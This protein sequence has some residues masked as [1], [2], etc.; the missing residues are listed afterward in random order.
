MGVGGG[1]GGVAGAGGD[2]GKRSASRSASFYIGG[3]R[4]LG[5]DRRGKAVGSAIK[6]AEP[7]RRR[8]S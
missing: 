6:N 8:D 1:G 5:G 2:E 7:S 4:V 3:S